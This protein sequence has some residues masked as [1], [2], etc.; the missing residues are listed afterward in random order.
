[1][2]PFG[3]LRV[4]PSSART[5]ENDLRRSR[6][7]ITASVT[8]SSRAVHAGELALDEPP[9]FLVRQAVL[10]E[11]IDGVGH[12]PLG[13][14]QR[15][16]S[17]TAGPAPVRDERAGALTQLDDALVLELAVGLGDGVRVDDERF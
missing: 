7:S 13:G 9:D 6:M 15:G 17:G 5:P 1:M 11:T 2:D 14:A 16:R 12:Q 8:S 3:T 10:A 4:R